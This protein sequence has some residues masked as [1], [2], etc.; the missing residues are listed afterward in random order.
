VVRTLAWLAV[1]LW[2]SLPPSGL[3]C[4]CGKCV[5]SSLRVPLLI[6]LWS[7]FACC[8]CLPSLQRP[9]P[10]PSREMTKFH[11]DDYVNFM[12]N[13]SPD[14]VATYASQLTRFNVGED[15]PVF[16]GLFQ[17]CQISAGGS[18]GGAAKLNRGDVDVAINWA[19]GLHH[20]KKAEA[21]GF[22]Y[23]NDIV[24][25]ILELLKVHKRV[26]YVDIDVHH[27]DGVE[28]AFYTSNRVMTLSFH[29][30]G[31]FF[32]GTG[33]IKDIG[34]GTG[35]NY[36]LNFPLH[37]GIDDVSYETIF[38][39]VCQMVMDRFR[40]EAIALQCGADSLT[41]DRIGCF[42]LTLHGHAM[43]VDYLK[44]FGIPMLVMGGGGYTIRN[45]SR[46]WT[47]ETSRLVD[48]EIPDQLPYN[49]YL[50]YFGPDYRLHIEPSNAPNHNSREYLER[51]LSELLKN[52]GQVEIA[53]SVQ[54][55]EIPP[56]ARV[57]AVYNEDALNPEERRPMA[58][59]DEQISHDQDLSDSDDDQGRKNMHDHSDDANIETSSSVPAVRSVFGIRDSEKMD[60][61]G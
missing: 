36:S 44:S 33:D 61:D 45:V 46:A 43:C 7:A 2:A 48:T 52:L 23:V 20:A 40:P 42:N 14:N 50:E 18:I 35:K 29:K 60:I 5:L 53:P 4:Q 57:V 12:K 58:L 31:E 21:S 6:Y 34:S 26:L 49:D 54:Q 38:K 27:G 22:C 3:F 13:V 16:A 8:V 15:C 10:T 56:E 28:E 24:L 47:Y 59:R 51:N 30:Y 11:T 1:A 37:D 25:G 9:I 32:P 17:F 55:M 19:G 41:G 39:P